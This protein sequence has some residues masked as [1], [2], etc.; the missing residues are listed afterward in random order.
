[1]A[2]AKLLG[3]SPGMVAGVPFFDEVFRQLDCTYGSVTLF[4]SNFD[5]FSGSLRV[6]EAKATM[7]V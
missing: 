2:Q 7:S 3:K 5:F 6:P 1:M 4:S